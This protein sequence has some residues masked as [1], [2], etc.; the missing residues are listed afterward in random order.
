[1]TLTL[2]LL[3]WF[4]GRPFLAAD[5]P[6]SR[7]S[8]PNFGSRFKQAPR[9]YGTGKEPSTWTYFTAERPSLSSTKVPYGS[10]K[11]ANAAF[12]PLAFR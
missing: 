5:R 11:T 2:S 1:M 12:M 7:P 3:N 10:W 4:V 9:L 8:R 6:S